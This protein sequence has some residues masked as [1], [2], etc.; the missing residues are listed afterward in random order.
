MKNCWASL[1]TPRAIHYR[2]Q[3]GIDQSNIAMAVIIQV[4]VPAQVAGVM[5]QPTRS[6]IPVREYYIE[7]VRGLGE[8]LVLGEKNADRYLVAKEKLAIIS[9]ETQ[10]GHPYLTDFQIKTLADYGPSWSICIR[11]PR[12][13]SGLFTGRNLCPANRPITTLA[14]ETSPSWNRQR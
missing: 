13:W 5:S 6:P 2:L 9:R 11:K 7:A 3:K 1:W 8:G 10:E 14:D 12:M 4:M